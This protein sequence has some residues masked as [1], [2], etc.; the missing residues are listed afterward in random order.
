MTMRL[1]NKDAWIVAYNSDYIVC[2]WMGLTKQMTDIHWKAGVTEEPIPPPLHQPFLRRLSRPLRCAV[3]FRA[4]HHRAGE[5][6][7]RLLKEET[8][9]CLADASDSG[10]RRSDRILPRGPSAGRNPTIPP[11]ANRRRF[12]RFQAVLRFCLSLQKQAPSTPYIGTIRLSP[13]SQATAG[14][15]QFS[16]EGADASGQYIYKLEYIKTVD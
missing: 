4:A 13:I 7:G 11:P 2:V 8:C 14:P 16:D 3:L 6:D 1:N 15:H 12:C 5:I 10:R 9:L